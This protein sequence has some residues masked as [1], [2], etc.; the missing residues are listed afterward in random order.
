M[1]VRRSPQTRILK[2]KTIT[3][4]SKHQQLGEGG[5]YKSRMEIWYCKSGNSKS[6]HEQEY[7][8][9]NSLKF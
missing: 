6:S 3:T 4:A 2:G 9:H 7:C 5:A 1:N 8:Y